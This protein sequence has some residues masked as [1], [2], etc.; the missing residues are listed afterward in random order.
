MSLTDRLAVARR[1]RSGTLPTASGPAALGDQ[2]ATGELKAKVNAQLLSTLGSQL[3]AADISQDDLAQRVRSVLQDVVADEQ[4]PMPTSE[5]IRLAQEIADDILGYG[6]I[7]PYL[8][9]PEITE[10]MVNGPAASISRR[11]AACI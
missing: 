1:E 9:D 10:V 4:T 8:R 7:E 6:P 2:D 11:P 3:Y 5:R